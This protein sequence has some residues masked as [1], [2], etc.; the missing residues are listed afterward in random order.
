MNAIRIAAACVVGVLA[1]TSCKKVL[2]NDEESFHTRMVNLISDSPTVQYKID[3]TIVSSTGYLSGTALAAARPGDHS[4]SFQVLRPASLVSTDT[5]DPIDLGGS[6]SRSYTK[7]TDYTIFAYGTL[8]NIQT[9][10]TDAPSGQAAVVD[11]NIEITVLNAAASQQMLTVYVTVPNAG[12]TAPQ[13]I[14]TISPGSRTTPSTLK[15]V[16]PA[17]STDTT[18][19]LTSDLTF[20]I[21]DASGAVIFTSPVLTTTEKTRY[22]FAITPNIGPGPSPVQLLA[23]D[24]S[25]G[26]YTNTT[27]QAALRL[28]HVSSATPTLDVYRATQLTSPLFSNIA[29][30]DHSPYAAVPQGVIDL[31]GV[32][33][34]STALQFLFIKEFTLLQGSNVSAYVIGPAASVGASIQTDSS[35]SIPTQGSFRFLIAAPSRSTTDATQ[36]LDIYVTIPGL[37][38]D[39]NTSTSVTTDDAAQFK[40]ATALIYQG[41]TDYITYKPDTPYQVRIMETGTSTVVL[42][43]TITV[44]AGAVQTYVVNDD[45]DTG[46]LELIPVDDAT[47]TP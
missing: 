39:F 8:A 45:P 37:V 38:L 16:R 5:T 24:G 9:L 30:R 19:D 14:G 28:V 10:I 12:I 29:F 46:A 22:L 43:T 3:S 6:F 18:S 35:R 7:N 27:D 20:E 11:D 40:R 23:I 17:N 2:N 33:A 31:L 25:S 32:P 26:V 42:D 44:P 21:H 15:L 13:S 4:I 47:P 34:G 36:G 41:V 1:L